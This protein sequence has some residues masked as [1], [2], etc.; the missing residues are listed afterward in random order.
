[1][2]FGVRRFGP[3]IGTAP[4]R[5][6]PSIAAYQPGTRGSGRTRTASQ[7]DSGRSPAPARTRPV[8]ARD[9]AVRKTRST[10]PALVWKSI[11]AVLAS[12]PNEKSGSPGRAPSNGRS[13]SAAHVVGR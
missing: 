2:S 3:G 5:M 12:M 7:R 8:W 6:Q 11:A 10:T 13:V 1:M 4:I 9:H